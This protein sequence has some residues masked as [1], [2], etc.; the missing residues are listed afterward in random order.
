MGA[1]RA[2]AKRGRGLARSS[3]VASAMV[4]ISLTRAAAALGAALALGASA[5]P[6]TQLTALGRLQPG[7]WQLR[8]YSAGTTSSL[9]VARRDILIQLEHRGA[10]CARTIIANDANSATVHYSCAGADFGR[11]T[12]RVESPRLATIDTQGI[13]RNAPF[14]YRVEARRVGACAR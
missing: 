10:D 14:A 1:W 9:C 2:K 4:N 6:Q 5:L 11:T 13:A 3:G 7:L 12:I 8:D